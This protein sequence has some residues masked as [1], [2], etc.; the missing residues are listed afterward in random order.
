MCKSWVWKKA[1]FECFLKTQYDE[2][3][4]TI[5]C[6]SCFAYKS[7]SSKYFYIE[8]KGSKGHAGE[9]K[10]TEQVETYS[11]VYH[12]GQAGTSTEQSKT[13]S[14]SKPIY[15]TPSPSKAIYRTPSPSA[16]KEEYGELTLTVY[17][18]GKAGEKEGKEETTVKGS[19]KTE[20]ERRAS[21]SPDVSE[22]KEQL[23]SRG[24]GSKGRSSLTPK[25]KEDTGSTFQKE[26]L[27]CP[28]ISNYD[29]PIEYDMYAKP[30]TF[31]RPEECCKKYHET[32]GKTNLLPL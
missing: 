20:S 30:F 10:Y 27:R 15:R 21:S 26:T 22:T 12:E 23:S 14:S 32:A 31:D 18:K 29:Q 17:H 25:T 8:K 28:Y 4:N 3:R 19:G 7:S 13:P 5:A 6:P 11:G 9:E 2:S 16:R 24:H 1:T